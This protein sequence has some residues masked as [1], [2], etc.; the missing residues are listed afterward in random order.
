[1]IGTV[2]VLEVTWSSENGWHPHV[3]ELALSSD[4]QMKPHAYDLAA[5]V[6][7]CD[8]TTVQGLHVKGHTRQGRG[9]QHGSEKL[10]RGIQ[11][12]S[13]R[14]NPSELLQCKQYG[15]LWRG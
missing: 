3:H 14:K 1:V 8:A 6:T 10:P 7:W 4:A 13:L 2:S 5:H 12:A 9:E 11:S 15:P